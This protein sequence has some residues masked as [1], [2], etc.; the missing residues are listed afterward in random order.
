MERERPVDSRR[1]F[2]IKP[3]GE[4]GD[5]LSMIGW[6]PFDMV[7]TEVTQYWMPPLADKMEETLEDDD[8]GEMEE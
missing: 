4:Y 7:I 6:K 1:F 8:E 5:H 2:F 3:A